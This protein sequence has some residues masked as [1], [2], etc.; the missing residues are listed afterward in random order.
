[1]HKIDMLLK[2]ETPEAKFIRDMGENYHF[3]IDCACGGKDG[4]Y[5]GHHFKNAEEE[6]EDIVRSYEPK[7]GPRTKYQHIFYMNEFLFLSELIS[8]HRKTKG[9]KPLVIICN[10]CG[11]EFSFTYESYS[12]LQKRLM[13][14]YNKKFMKR[15]KIHL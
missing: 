11:R 6:F 12:N 14:E 5:S 4:E 15:D 9:Q 2:L 3:G 8:E 10:D 13:T 1:M 7:S